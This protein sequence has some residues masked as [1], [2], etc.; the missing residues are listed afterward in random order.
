MTES[1]SCAATRAGV[2]G[3]RRPLK[4]VL[5]PLSSPEEEEEEEQQACCLRPLANAH[6][7]SSEA[8]S[9]GAVAKCFFHC[10]SPPNLSRQLTVPLGQTE[11]WWPSCCRCCCCCFGFWKEEEGRR[12][13]VDDAAG[14]EFFLF[15]FLAFSTDSNP[16]T[17]TCPQRLQPLGCQFGSRRSLWCISMLGDEV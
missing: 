5:S 11:A 12:S 17:L 2:R 9:G 15:L 1:R 6:E 7:G 16:T 13:K 8:S 4:S 10:S 14:G 3:A